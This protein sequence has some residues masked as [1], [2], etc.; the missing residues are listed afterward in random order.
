[1]KITIL[2]SILVFLANVAMA[3]KLEKPR[4][5]LITGDTTLQ[6]SQEVL[7]NKFSLVTDYLASRVIYLNKRYIVD[8]HIIK[9]ISIIFST[10]PG[11]KCILKLNSGKLLTLT[12]QLTQM[13]EF[14]QSTYGASAEGD[15][16]FDLTNDDI[17]SIKSG[18]IAVIRIETS[19]APFDY[20]ISDKKSELI[21]K[22]IELIQ[23]RK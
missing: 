7:T 2:V 12:T 11:D 17:E 15:A 19:A 16:W 20:E 18:R 10:H 9:G 22:Q 4:I 14:K 13:S 8:F 3:Q 21:K 1:M 6:T 5:D 23:N